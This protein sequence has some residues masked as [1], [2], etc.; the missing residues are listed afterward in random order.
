MKKIFLAAI[1][2]S[3]LTGCVQMQVNTA[4]DN[5]DAKAKAL[6]PVKGKALIYI[7][8]PTM[9]GKP[10]A[11]EITMDGKKIGSTC[12]YYYIYTFASPG[13][14]KLTATGDYTG[15]LDLTVEAGKTYYIEHKVFPALWKGGAS[16]AL[17]NGTDGKKKLG[18]CKLSADYS[19]QD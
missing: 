8:R 18:E 7:I 15:E 6:T 11:H 5:A 4:P 9:L 12:G 13:K 17:I 3:F 19:V 2:L 16:L 14:H 10:F 1:I